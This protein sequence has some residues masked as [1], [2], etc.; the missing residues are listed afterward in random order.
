[1]G[2]KT[3]SRR[4]LLSKKK[5]MNKVK[6]RFR[7]TKE[8]TMILKK[9]P[10][11]KTTKKAKIKLTKPKVDRSKKTSLIKKMRDLAKSWENEK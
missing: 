2:R 1:M 6:G 3:K 10:A 7:E 5:R 8:Y 4:T 9:K 11:K